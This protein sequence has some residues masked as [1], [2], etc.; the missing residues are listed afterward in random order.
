MELEDLKTQWS[1]LSKKIDEQQIINN[2]VMRTAVSQKMSFIKSYNLLGVIIALLAIP[3]L[4]VVHKQNNIDIALFYF[5]IISIV[6]ISGFSIYLS[7]Q[8]AKRVNMK[9]NIID[10]EL[11]L[12]KYNRNYYISSIVSYIWLV[13]FLTW[14]LI[15][16]YDSIVASNFLAETIAMYIGLIVFVVWVEIRDNGRLRELQKYISDLKAFEAEE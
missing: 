6:I 5:T 12:H 2:R 14:T 13:V 11:F 8:F 1:M 7:I 4:I 16:Y 9:T 15:L 10:L 3:F